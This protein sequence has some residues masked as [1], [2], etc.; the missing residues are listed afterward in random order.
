MYATGLEYALEKLA[1]NA[2]TKRLLSASPQKAKSLLSQLPKADRA[3]ASYKVLGNKAREAVQS[4]MPVGAGHGA[5]HVWDVTRDAQGLLGGRIKGR[6][7]NVAAGEA[8]MPHDTYRRGVLSSLLH[9]VGRPAEGRVLKGLQAQ[10]G[11][12]PGKASFKQQP[13]LWHSELSGRHAK[14]FLQKNQ[15]VAKNVPGLDKG[16]LSGAIRGHDTDIHKKLP[17]TRERLLDDPAAGA[18]YLA[19]KTQGLGAKGV[20]RTLEMGQQFGETPAETYNFAVGK[21]VPKYQKAIEDF[22]PSPTAR[23]ALMAK[24]D[25]YRTGMEGFA[26][27]HNVPIARPAP[28]QKAAMAISDFTRVY[29]L[30]LNNP[31]QTGASLRKLIE[32]ASKGNPKAKSE[33]FAA[34]YKIPRNQRM[35]LMEALKGL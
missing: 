9:D 1:M 17:W 14:N 34:I 5:D 22:A 12:K 2:L 33:A 32:A 28:L 3:Q 30:F 18:T 8:S 13:D 16:Q 23:E 25:D 6:P 20:D 21:N 19:D 35:R 29:R 10:L 31:G 26:Q 4:S 11:K 15:Q 24:L 27:K 7:T